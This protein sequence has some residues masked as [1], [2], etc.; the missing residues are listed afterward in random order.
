MAKHI[1]NLMVIDEEQLYAEH[2]VSLLS[3]Y[4]DEVNLGFWDEK[5]ELIKSLR[6][7][8][9]VLV[10]SRAYD[11]SLTDV[12]GILQEHNATLPII[13]LLPMEDGEILP[14]TLPETIDGDM[15]KTLV[16]G[17]DSMLVMAI[18]LQASYSRSVRQMR[19][20]RHIISEAE[21]RANVLISNSK[22]AVAYMEQGVHVYANDPYLEMFGYNSIDEIVGV[23][24]VDLFA[25]GE[26]IKGFKQ[27]L[28]KFDKGDRSQVEFAFE[29]K[30]TDGT[31]FESTLQLAAATLNGEPVTQMIIQRNENVDAEEIAKRLAE[32]ER[33]DTLTGLANRTGFMINLDD[34]FSEVVQGAVR[35]SVLL[36]INLDNIGKINSS[37]GLQGV[38]TTIRFMGH[39]FNEHFSDGSVARF[40][41]S[42]FMVILPDTTKEKATDLAEKVRAKAET[43]LIEVG[44][45][46]VTTTLSIG[47][48]IMDAT[49]PDAQTA[50]NRVVE[51]VA[52]ISAETDGVG[53]A[54]RVFDISEHA[55]DDEG[56]LGEYI[57][58]ALAQNRFKLHY[59]PIYDI[60]NDN[61]DLFEVFVTLPMADGNELTIDKFAHIAKKNNLADK[62]DRWVLIN[63]C[64]QLA[65]TRKEHPNARLLVSLSSATLG[66][67]Q[68]PKI[69]TQLVKAIGEHGTYPLT[70]QFH[71]QDLVDYLAV[72]K[73]QFMAL[74]DIDCPVGLHAFG[75]TAK[76]AEILAHLNPQ[77]AR[78]AR[79]YT[80]DLDRPANMETVQALV[81]KATECRCDVLMPYISDAQT[82]SMAWSIG[83]RY[84]QGDY[85][86]PAAEEMVYVLP[87][88]GEAQ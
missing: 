22:S 67:A 33:Q 14:T 79:P 12:V 35:S 77:I 38:D 72:A 43:L 81:G 64:K 18:C 42:T 59:Q 83:A 71:E 27:F 2:L 52:N 17:Q 46:T 65:N 36:Y 87:E 73:R 3:T 9:D 4:F 1:L 69:V 39:L 53:N 15:I 21:L 58:N 8:W 24:V 26:A 85:L 74:A 25:S 13:H 47:I 68:L 86:Q 7:D 49:T 63:A 62:L 78:L 29:S 88:E 51:T 55:G 66:D 60:N 75:V 40:S 31:T 82:M 5:A 61:N 19:E 30:R 34:A 28:R 80:K 57:Q 16:K 32:V 44:Q 6:N 11:M 54:V 20:L 48:V 41:D 76:S 10:F 50:L 37:T 56:A 23:P 45:R 70:L 84:L